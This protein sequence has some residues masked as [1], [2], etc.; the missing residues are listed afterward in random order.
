M[1]W[2]IVT[3]TQ[4]GSVIEEAQGGENDNKKK[5]MLTPYDIGNH[6]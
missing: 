6:R 4:R 2:N 3:G 1:K 5:E